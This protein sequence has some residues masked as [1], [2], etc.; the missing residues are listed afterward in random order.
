MYTAHS[1]SHAHTH[2]RTHAHTCTRVQVVVYDDL[3]NSALP[4][5][6]RVRSLASSSTPNPGSLHF[7]L[8]DV[9]DPARLSEVLEKYRP[10]SCIHFA[11]LKAVG[12]SGEKPLDY[13]DCNIGERGG[14][15]CFIS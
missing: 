5:L 8:G 9:R 14:L 13:Y 15:R 7:E 2:T 3:S 6:D 12:E 4:A 10:D 11:G 1:S